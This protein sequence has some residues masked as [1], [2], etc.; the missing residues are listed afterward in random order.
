MTKQ[1]IQDIFDNPD[2]GC[3]GVVSPVFL[4]RNI[5]WF[6]K[7]LDGYRF[8][9]ALHYVM[10]VNQSIS[11]LKT[12]RESWCRVDVSSYN[13]LMGAI[14]AWFQGKNITANWPKNRKFLEKCIEINCVIA[15]DNISELELLIL[16]L[17]VKQKRI[18]ILLRISG[19]KE[20][21]ST[22]FGILREHWEKS[23][24]ILQKHQN[25][26]DILGYSFHID[27]RGIETRQSVFW[28]SIEYYSLLIEGWWNPR[29]ID[30]GGG[31]GARYQ[32]DTHIH[33]VS[34]TRLHLGSRLYP[35]D[36]SPVWSDFLT[37]FLGKSHEGKRSI[38]K[39]LEENDIELWIEPGRSL[40][41]GVGYVATRII[42]IRTD[43][44]SKSL[45]LDTNSFALGMRE[46]E[47]P[48]D[49][50][51]LG[52]INSGIY[53]YSLLGNLCLESDIIYCR[54]VRLQAEANIWDILI[55]PDMAGYHMDFYE[56]Q[57]IQHPS[58]S[59]YLEKNGT[60]ISDN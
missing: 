44:G 40:L 12:A 3:I 43:S 5:A 56:T 28:E 35:Q 20:A 2:I 10:K 32:D 54:N 51:I 47:L 38:G 30:I 59:R 8:P 48:T 60:L 13:E 22:R 29:I 6:Q 34:C 37:T 14:E 41:S 18:S 36:D 25:I 17:Q 4:E 9:S 39:F 52:K 1:D 55:F 58:K 53:E 33:N 50:I 11:L 42:W 7:I 19:F 21:R 45:V 31:Y 24:H 16:E 15:V 23:I 57:S 26:V 27:S 46:E 49:P